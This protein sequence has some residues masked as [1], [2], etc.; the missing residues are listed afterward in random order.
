MRA[1]E[2]PRVT[3][4]RV[5]NDYAAHLSQHY[6]QWNIGVSSMLADAIDLAPFKD[7]FWSNSNEPD[8]PCKAS[9]IEPVPDRE[10]LIA[11]LS[12]GPVAPGDAIKYTDANCIMRCCNE[13]GLIL[14]PDRPIALI[15][16]LVADWAQNQGVSQSELYS[17]RSTLLVSFSTFS[18]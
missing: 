10:I 1:L 11:T 14:K 13:N 15:E 9:A 3:Q 8:S 6:S 12:I 18:F 4:A 7:V 2:I 17:T 5:S 16:Q